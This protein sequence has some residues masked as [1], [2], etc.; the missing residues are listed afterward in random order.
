MILAPNLLFL[1]RHQRPLAGRRCEFYQESQLGSTQTVY[2]Y[3][4]QIFCN[5]QQ[6]RDL[7]EV[8]ELIFPIW[9]CT[10]LHC[11]ELHEAI[12][13]LIRVSPACMAFTQ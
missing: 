2:R 3:A 12:P 6:G 4:T 13:Y 9:C 11:I 7:N 8:M 10:D 1:Y 5:S